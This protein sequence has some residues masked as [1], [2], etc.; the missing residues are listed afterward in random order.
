MPWLDRDPPKQPTL[1][2]AIPRDEGIAIGIIDDR[3]NDSAYYTI[4]RA[5]GK[6]KWIYKTQKFTYY[7]KENKTW[8]NLCR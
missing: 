7:C 3:E 1:K 5:N 6:M 2:G 4:Y 8:R